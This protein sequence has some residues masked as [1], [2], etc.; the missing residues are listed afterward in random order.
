M[1]TKYQKAIDEAL[2]TLSFKRGELTRDL[3][4]QAQIEGLDRPLTPDEMRQ[5]PLGQE[6]ALL[7]A[8]AEGESSAAK[9]EIYETWQH[10]HEVLFCPPF[11]NA[12]S[13]PEGFYS[14]DLGQMLQA[15]RGRAFEEQE[16]YTVQEVASELSLHVMYVYQLISRN[17]LQAVEVKG[18]KMIPASEVKR[19]Q[20]EHP[21]HER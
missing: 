8:V 12:Y 18:K 14:T 16:L 1:N 4:F 6:L 10:I 19:Y 17:K 3:S 21:K 15:A 20:E 5:G 11:A 2:S 13:I 9:G 7:A